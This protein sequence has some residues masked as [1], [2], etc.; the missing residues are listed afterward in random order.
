[1]IAVPKEPQDASKREYAAVEESPYPESGPGSVANFGSRLLAFLVDAVLADVI[2]IIVNG[3]YHTSDRQNLSVYLAFL[4]LEIVFVAAASQ[5]P[6]MRVAGIAVVR[7]DG[8]GRP[9]LQWVL[10]RTLLLAVVA[11]ALVIDTQ[12]RAMHDRAAGTVILRT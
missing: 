9:K 3:G 10:L 11:P 6:G 8:R 2:G 4:L 7:E 5:T 1:V 12:G